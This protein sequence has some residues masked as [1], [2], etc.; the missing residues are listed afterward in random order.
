MRTFSAIALSPKISPALTPVSSPRRFSYPGLCPSSIANGN[1]WRGWGLMVTVGLVVGLAGGLA[2]CG[3]SESAP[4]RQSDRNAASKA[5]VSE[6]DPAIA[7]ARSVWEI[8]PKRQATLDAIAAEIGSDKLPGLSCDQPKS[9]RIL[10]GDAR[11]MMIGYC[12]DARAIVERHRLN[13]D[14][15]N[16]ITIALESDTDLRKAVEAELLRL[17]QP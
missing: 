7:Y 13:S 6:V 2:G 8:E 12:N 11:R 3:G 5:A 17:Q 14:E 9:L 1:S 16:Q 4:Q 15:F 10:R